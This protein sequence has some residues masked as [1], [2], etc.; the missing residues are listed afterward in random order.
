MRFRVAALVFNLRLRQFIAGLVV[1]IFQLGLERRQLS[2]NFLLGFPLA[3]DFFAI[4]TQE[5]IDSLDTDSD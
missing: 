1:F 3:N 4:A 2:L 5:V